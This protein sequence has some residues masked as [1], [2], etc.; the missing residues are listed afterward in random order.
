MRYTPTYR[1]YVAA[2]ADFDADF[3]KLEETLRAYAHTGEMA[4]FDGLT[5]AYEYYLVEN[6]TASVV[7]VHGFTE[8]MRKYR[9][10]CRYFMDMGFNVFLYD[11]RG[12]GRS[13][14]QVDEWHHAHVNA[15]DDYVR[16]LET[17]VDELVRPAAGDL[18]LYLYSHSMGGA[19]VGFYMQCHP[20]AAAKAILS[21]PMVDPC[22]H[23]A[24]RFAMFR[25]L[26]RLVKQSGWDARFPYGGV[27][28]ENPSF[29]R[30]SDKSYARFKMN[31]DTRLSDVC[32]QNASQ[33]NRWMHETLQVKK[34]FLNREKCKAIQ[35]QVLLIN[36]GQDR[37]VRT[38][39]QKQL[40][41]RLMNVRYITFPDGKHTLLND[42]GAALEQYY[43]CLKAFLSGE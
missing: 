34:R 13:G 9:E 4:A 26:K 30:S 19:V 2:E 1:P 23:G 31:F 38:R 5:L 32:Y 7:I 21:S 41:R 42:T 28:R 14:R 6:A 10:M 12:H 39:P 8:F 29:E 15:F 33:T 18:P 40:A 25:L 27:W 17:V 16:D 35:T 20:Q 3:A 36:A 24:P 43:D 22:M 37:V 11:Q